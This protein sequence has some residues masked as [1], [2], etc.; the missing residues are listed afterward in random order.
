LHELERKSSRY[1]PNENELIDASG[2]PD[3]DLDGSP[4]HALLEHSAEHTRDD[5]IG[6]DPDHCLCLVLFSL[7]G[8]NGWG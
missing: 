5:S 3:D 6:S 1:D 7:T 2:D 8:P 4:G